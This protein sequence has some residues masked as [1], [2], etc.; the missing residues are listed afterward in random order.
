MRLAKL[1]RS[2]GKFELHGFDK[3]VIKEITDN[4]RKVKEKSLFVAI[5]GLTHDGHD[6]IPQAIHAGAAAIVGERPY[7][8]IRENPAIYG[9]DEL[10][11]DMSSSFRG[12]PA[13]LTRRGRH[14]RVGV[15]KATYIKVR[16][17]RKALG[18]LASAWYGNPS[19]KMKII[20]VTGTDGKTTT[21]N[22]IY[23][24]LKSA[25]KKVGLVSTI[26]A[27]IG[28]KEIDTGLHVTNPEPLVLQA[29]LA[30]MVKAR[31]EYA[32]LEVT[33]HGLDQERVAGV[34]FKLGVLTNIT[35]EHLDYHK[36][37]DNYLRAKAKLFKEVELSILNKDDKS[38]SKF[39]KLVHGR[40]IT[41]GTRKADFAP[42][43][44]PFS[45]SLPGAYNRYNIL[46]AMAATTTLGIPD[47][48]IRCAIKTFKGLEGRMQEVD[49]GQ[50]V[51]VFVDFAH[52][53][54]ALENVLRT[55]KEKAIGR[56]I[57][58][59]GCAGER[60]RDKRGAM[61]EISGKLADIS[62]F[63]AEDP[64][65][66]NV[67]TI[68][69]EMAKGATEAGARKVGRIQTEKLKDLNTKKHLFLK[70]PERGEAIAFALQKLARKDDLIAIC[71]KGHEKSMAYDG[72]EYPWSD[73][74]AVQAALR[75]GVKKLKR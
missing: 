29:L 27:K 71:G 22:L 66:E 67:N 33:S 20:G 50:N 21:A 9:G 58:V 26:S 23:W 1:L 45:T 57:V 64:R 68:I 73:A 32:V 17:S 30:R 5:K 52:T 42:S 18:Q 59:F 54:N 12:S 44:V 39:K 15:K 69:E 38:F 10:N 37:F 6:Y 35:H 47:K 8:S 53:P 46:A 65:G 16:D 24:I 7:N 19:E 62:V 74:E 70:I 14:K 40:I 51:K 34:D 60:D 43:K 3:E 61:G 41:Y 13:L 49:E 63:T 2:L 36:T 48:A 56:L 25:G 28:N 75:G 72:K 4:S 11:A 31:C 55:L